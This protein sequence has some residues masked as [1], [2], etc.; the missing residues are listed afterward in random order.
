MGFLKRLFRRAEP[1][2][3]QAVAGGVEITATLSEGR[4]RIHAVG[5]SHYQRGLEEIAGGRS[6]RGADLETIALLV[7][8]PNNRYDPNAVA[9]WIEGKTIGYLS[10]DNAEVLQPEISRLHRQHDR[11]VACRAR[12]VG[13]WDR[14]PG[15]RGHFGV[16]LYLDPADFGVDPEDLDG[17]WER[18]EAHTGRTRTPRAG[19]G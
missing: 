10:R 14:G 13:G 18:P 3:L 9:V 2:W 5:E 4:F 12:I 7:P 6:D 16:R 11:P 17:E 15:D 1:P 8:E 19:G